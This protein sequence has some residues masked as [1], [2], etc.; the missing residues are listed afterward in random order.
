MQKDFLYKEAETFIR[1]Y[2]RE[3]GLE[4]VDNRLR[5]I[6]LEISQTGTY[7]HTNQELVF[8]AKIAWRNSIRCIGRLFYDTLEVLDFRKCKSAT[9]VMSGLK[10]HLEIATNE[11]KLRSVISIFCPKH[12]VNGD[13][14]RIW[15]S[16]LIRYA[17]Y[18]THDGVIGDPEEVEFTEVCMQLGW[19][20]T[21]SHFDLLPV[22][23]QMPNQDPVWYELE[24]KSALEIELEH[25][26]FEWFKDLKLRWYAVPVVADMVLRIGGLQ[27]T[28]AP[29]SGWYMETEIGS[30]NLGDENRYN[31][32]PVIARK[33]GLDIRYERTLWKDRALIE[34]NRAVL[35]SFQKKGVRIVDHHSASKQ[36]MTFCKKEK[37]ERRQV[38]ADW[39]WIVPPMSASSTEVFHCDWEN[40]VIDPNFYYD[41]PA[42]KNDY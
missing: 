7:I 14:I 3:A 1:N 24:S 19:R 26:D 5:A 42:W 34:L 9:E 13:E 29:F 17:G 2:Y 20:G 6:Q 23:I 21:V 28:A 40:K 35:H 16:K 4:N 37:T 39:G 27:Y 11:G 33:M 41:K 30:R 15:N 31:Q 12:P 32:L 25:P 10:T 38:M 18:R 8:G 36:F 22:V